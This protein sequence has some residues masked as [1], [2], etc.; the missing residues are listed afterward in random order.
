M[1]ETWPKK[2]LGKI[3][4][5]FRY[6]A[7]KISELKTLLSESTSRAQREIASCVAM[8][9]NRLAGVREPSYVKPFASVVSTS[10]AAAGTTTSATAG[11]SFK[12]SPQYSSLEI[13]C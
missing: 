1:K 3:L 10:A 7:A 11:L 5:D 4:A 6:E 13:F 12:E 8:L 9:S 2:G